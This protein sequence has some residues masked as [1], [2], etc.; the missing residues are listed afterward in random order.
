MSSVGLGA[1]T[2]A[3]WV[4][5]GVA[6]QP[7]LEDLGLPL[8][9][10]TFV[11]VDLETTGGRSGGDA[12]TEFGAVKVRGGEVLGEFQTLVNPGVP[13][14]AQITVLTGITNAMVLPAPRID[15]VFPAFLEF[16]RGAVL[17]AHNA[18]FDI[19]FLRAAAR[20]TGHP[21]PGNQVVDTVRLARAAVTRDEVPNHKLSTLAGFFRA[22]VTP[23]HRA[24]SDARATVDVL[25]ALLGRLA[26]AGVTHLEDLATAGD[27]VPM[28]VRRKRH[29]ADALPEAPGVYLFVGPGDEVL[30][31]GTS[32]SLRSRVRT[33]FTAAETRKAI[34]EMV[35]IAHDVRPV[36]CATELEAQ[37]RELRLIAEHTPRY[38]RRSKFPQRT[39]WVRLVETGVPRLSVVREVV[40]GTAHLGPFG[41][42]T[43]AQ[44]AAL[45]LLSAF[46]PA[47]PGT[48]AAMH[49]EAPD[50][51]AVRSAMLED[52][53]PVVAAHARAIAAMTAAQNFE[54]AAALRDRLSVFLR[55][56]SRVQR[57]A[58]LAATP[59]LVAARPHDGGG[60][61]LVVVRHAR[62]AATGLAL[63]GVDPVPVIESLRAAAEH[64]PTPVAPAP[65]G[66][67]EEAELLLGWLESPGVRLVELTGEVPWACP[68]AGAPAHTDLA[69][70]AEL[71]RHHNAPGP[72]AA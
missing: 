70:T 43:Q 15:E 13:V 56:A 21:W 52:P 67:A 23:D 7:T 35:R 9:E 44:Q 66:L 25:H 37:V 45:A 65:G 2:T 29:M 34:K 40:D 47:V 30:Y 58:P 4:A 64:V 59:E 27:N 17:V 20:A 14:P 6:V 42:R 11:V 69:R 10:V 24:L 55:G 39:S 38:N 26:G 5:P 51:P 54:A 33:Y 60:W 61:E 12:I 16:I 41:S 8:H 49:L 46:R 57:L 48:R 3:G 62:L 53:E 50:V 68:V 19:G 36:V 72:D 63:R 22:Q 71:V 32:K 1:G 18:P 31:V 28:A